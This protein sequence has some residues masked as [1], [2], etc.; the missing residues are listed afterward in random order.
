MLP[1]AGGKVAHVE[2]VKKKS[3]RNHL[4]V[5]L[6]SILGYYLLVNYKAKR[7]FSLEKEVNS[8]KRY[9]LLSIAAVAVTFLF[10]ETGCK[11]NDKHFTAAGIWE[12]DQTVTDDDGNT[13]TKTIRY[14]FTGNE[15]EG[16]V[17]TDPPLSAGIY[18]GK[19]H[20]DGNQIDF[21]YGRG[22]GPAWSHNYYTGEIYPG[23][24]MMKGT[25][26][27]NDT[28]SGVVERSWAGPFT[29]TKI[30]E[31]TNSQ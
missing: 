16:S 29:A 9:L 5:D 1:P 14:K 25:L 20:V 24:E 31:D 26:T 10:I 21:S 23:I 17:A 22:R 2:D 12:L 19:Y 30:E 13:D 27:G 15:T 8:M 7:G 4:I 6:N 18:S 3:G 11:S 28:F